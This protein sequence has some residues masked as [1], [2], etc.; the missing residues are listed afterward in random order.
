MECHFW[1]IF[2]L[3]SAV[4]IL[5]IPS[6]HSTDFEVHRNWLAITHSLPISKWYYENTSNWTLDYPPFFAYFEWL[7]SYAASFVDPQMVVVTN[8]NYASTATIYFQRCSVIIVDLVFAVGVRRSLRAL[9]I[10]QSSSQSFAATMLLLFNVGLSF[11]DHM[12]FQ[13]NGF[14]FGIL[15]LSISFLLEERYLLAAFT[16][17]SLLMFKHIFLYMA[18]AFA[19]YLLKFYCLDS[20]CT[21]NAIICIAKLAI[22]GL[23]PIIAAF[24]PFYNQMDQVF[25][26]LFPFK[27]GLTH[28]YWAPN[29]WALYNTAD[30]VVAKLLRIPSPI[31][32]STTSGLVQE[33]EPQFLP[34]ITPRT[35]FVLTLLFMLPILI[36]LFAYTSKSESKATFLRA[37]VICS[38]SSFMFGWHVH[39]KAILMCLLPLCL[40][41]VLLP[42]DA[43]Y[44]YWLS[45]FGYFSLFPLLHQSCVLLL[46]YALYLAYVAFMYGQ[47]A[48]LYPN[49]RQTKLHVLEKLYTVGCVLI[50]I[51]E[52][53]ISPFLHLD[54]TLPF[55]PLLLTSLYCGLAVTYF[56]IR[57]YLHALAISPSASFTTKTN[58]KPNTTTTKTVKAKDKSK[59]K[60]F[61][62]KLKAQ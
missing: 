39:E 36:K 48:N 42:T 4:K 13:Y 11:V 40:L 26:R 50:P 57:Y 62:S 24:G 31:G 51:Y 37:V 58:F 18:P 61:K 33:F 30:K 54:K 38:C 29:F 17:A 3:S 60:L 8:L 15:L 10:T 27:R 5:L 16:F 56:F 46:R 59:S 34:N 52:H 53:F 14:L 19:V 55:L 49:E 47:L 22:V 21:R 25:S 41:F 7:L 23:T 6:P 1:K 35:T 44:A 9:K 45:I 12:H 32:P 20:K 43:T 28:A 2:A